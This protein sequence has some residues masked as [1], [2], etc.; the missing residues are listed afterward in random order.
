MID[1]ETTDVE[2]KSVLDNFKETISK[3]NS[4]YDIVGDIII[5]GIDQSLRPYYETIGKTLL[6]IHPQ[7]KTVLNKGI[8]LIIC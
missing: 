5:I 3:I 6:E 8:F 4:A 2:L 1:I 7:V